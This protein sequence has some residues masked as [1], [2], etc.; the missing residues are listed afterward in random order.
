MRKTYITSDTHFNHAKMLEF[1]RPPD[2]EQRIVKG[3]SVI[4]SK[5]TLIHLGDIC[6]GE[7][8]M[9]HQKF[10]QPIPGRKILVVGNHDRKSYNWYLEHGWDFVCDMFYWKAFGKHILFSHTPKPKRSI[11][12]WDYNIH[13]HLHNNTH[14]LPQYK[15]I[16]TDKHLLLALENT[17]YLPVILENFIPRK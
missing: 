7:D 16:L 14:H 6:I 4:D 9:V 3:L 11:N 10:I 2:Y 15:N 17:N 13:G 8:E 5:D 12:F 1:G